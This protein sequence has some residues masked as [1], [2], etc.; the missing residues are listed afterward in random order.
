[1]VYTISMEKITV[2]YDGKCPL[3]YKEI[4]HYKKKDVNN[5]LICIDI[6]HSD[7]NIKDYKGLNMEEV[8]LKLHAITE[9]GEVYTGIDTFVEIWKRIPNFSFFISLVNNP[10][11]RPAFDVFYI[12]FARHIRPKLPKRGCDSGSCELKL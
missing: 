5:L 7:F 11:L 4:I 10:I 8:N 12:I 9:S 2:L 3:C 6:A 1:M